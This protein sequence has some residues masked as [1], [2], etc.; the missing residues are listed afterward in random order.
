MRPS[1]V[2]RG[3][4]A[5]LASLLVVVAAAP[6]AHAERGIP[7]GGGTLSAG[8][9]SVSPDGRAVA[10]DDGN[11]GLLSTTL[12]RT[13]VPSPVKRVGRADS[14]GGA[15]I[16]AG[17]DGTAA[18]VA[19]FD[20]LLGAVRPA[21][22]PFGRLVPFAPA[23]KGRD[24][25]SVATSGGVV[26]TGTDLEV[27]GPSPVV[28]RR[29]ADGTTAAPIVLPQT[30]GFQ[31]E[32]SDVQVAVDAAGRGVA[33]WGTGVGD[34]RHTALA[35][36]A[37][38]G[39]LGPVAALPGRTSADRDSPVEVRVAPDGTGAVAWGNGKLTAVAPLTTT[40][41]VDLS[42]PTTVPMRGEIGLQADGAAVVADTHKRPGGRRF[43]VVS[44]AAGKPFTAMASVPTPINGGASVAISD[45]HWVGASQAFGPGA[46]DL[47]RAVAIHGDAGGTPSKVVPLPVGFSSTGDVLAAAPG[48]TPVVLFQ[49]T[50]DQTL[51][52]SVPPARTQVFRI[53]SGAPRPAG[54]SVSAARSQRLGRPQRVRMT[55]RCS[56]ACSY[57]VLT[58]FVY[59]KDRNDNGQFDVS[60]RASRGTHRIVVPFS[61]VGREN[62]K[63]VPLRVTRKVRFTIAVD[64]AR[65]GQ[66]VFHRT[67]TIRP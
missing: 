66:T 53:G 14:L 28:L 44:R 64:D 37:A 51:G 60:R 22:G 35:T 6:A 20:R 67:I 9:V 4:P 13:G 5:V 34:D 32:D 36:I 16:A 39:T 30:P 1:S 17:A 15:L 27:S 42:A 3:V 49:A 8:A 25:T 29:A 41:G 62:G 38:D 40:G 47:T 65:G 55:V 46:D 31:G 57:R 2:P 18:V 26:L 58:D 10:L 54:A 56:T 48:G 52:S 12:S 50:R 11:N 59:A 23:D 61:G 63:D 33:T 7:L 19:G 43:E 24:A 21:G 45:G